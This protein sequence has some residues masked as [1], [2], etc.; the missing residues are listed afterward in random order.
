MPNY[1]D[2][3]LTIKNFTHKNQQI[4]N[5]EIYNYTLFR[6]ILSIRIYI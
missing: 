2:S 3:F 5:L 6:F 1:N 4:F